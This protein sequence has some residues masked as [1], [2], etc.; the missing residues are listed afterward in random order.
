MPRLYRDLVVSVIVTQVVDHSLGRAANR[1][2]VS[3]SI[4]YGPATADTLQ[5][6]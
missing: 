1:D 4:R 2:P 6:S 5:L 3:N